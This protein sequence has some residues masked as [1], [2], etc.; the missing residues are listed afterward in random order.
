MWRRDQV[1]CGIG[2]VGGEARG[3]GGRGGEGGEGLGIVCNIYTVSLH[4][5]Y[6]FVCYI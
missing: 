3:G 4:T 6:L 1:N 5:S 2:G